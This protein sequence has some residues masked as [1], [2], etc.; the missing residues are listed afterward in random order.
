MRKHV[1]LITGAGGEI[2]HGLIERL[3]ADGDTAIIT[4][5]LQPIDHSLAAKVEQE[6]QGSILETHLLER[7]L[8]EYRV[9]RI[10]HLAAILSTRA[11]P[12]LPV[13][14]LRA[15]GQLTEL[16]VS[17]LR[18]THDESAAFLREE[19]DL[20]LEPEDMAALQART[21][22]WIVGLQ[23]AA[24]RWMMNITGIVIITCSPT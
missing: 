9:E 5:D 20:D 22:G 16:R 21:E 4:I 3:T 7:I 13:S 1:T 6:Y 10:Y 14:R 15:R 11:D 24:F 23:L 8:S 12:P 17:D 2:G 19:M 18:F